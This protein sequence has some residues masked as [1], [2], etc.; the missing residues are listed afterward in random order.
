[1]HNLDVL[2]PGG[3]TNPLGQLVHAAAPMVLMKRPAGQSE[4]TV[5]AVPSSSYLPTGH[6]LQALDALEPG[7]AYVVLGQLVH[8]A[9]PVVLAKRPA[10]QSVHQGERAGS[11][12]RPHM[13]PGLYW[14]GCPHL[15]VLT[16]MLQRALLPL[17]LLVYEQRPSHL[18]AILSKPPGM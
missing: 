6:N 15:C 7:G 1:M 3:P 18:L 9:A 10:G 11:P 4:H 2:E 12:F 17:P 8:A 16:G 5:L 13:K 14:P